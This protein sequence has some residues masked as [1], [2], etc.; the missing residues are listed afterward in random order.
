ML[1]EEFSCHD[2]LFSYCH[3]IDVRLLSRAT[4]KSKRKWRKVVTGDPDKRIRDHLK[5]TPQVRTEK[6]EDRKR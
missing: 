5:E 4:D 6:G 3:D 1:N 2:T